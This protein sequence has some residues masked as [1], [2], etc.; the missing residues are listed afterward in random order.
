MERKRI[1][2]NN[3]NMYEEATSRL[4]ESAKV[5]GS[6][7]TSPN[8]E[9]NTVDA[10]HEYALDKIP[11]NDVII[12]FPTKVNKLLLK[13][14]KPKGKDTGEDEDD[15]SAISF[16]PQKRWNAKKI[17][18]LFFNSQCVKPKYL[19]DYWRKIFPKRTSWLVVEKQIGQCNFNLLLFILKSHNYK[20]FEN[21]NI[22]SIKNTLIEQ[23]QNL[24][25]DCKL[26][27]KKKI[28]A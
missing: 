15:S 9:D 11:N 3:A 10:V 20:K 6:I 7:T 14:P 2:M 12:K 16:L 27:E 13:M 26:P 17:Y 1:L 18:N 5:N 8:A 4:E 23:Y 28:D 25:F 19:T 24:I 22:D 21:E